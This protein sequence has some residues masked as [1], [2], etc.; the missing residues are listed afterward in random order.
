MKKNIFQ[1]KISLLGSDPLIWRTVHVQPDDTLMELHDIIQIVFDWDELHLWKFDV[2]DAEYSVPDFLSEEEENPFEDASQMT[3]AEVFKKTGVK[4]LYTYDFGDNWEHEVVLEKKVEKN[5]EQIYPICIDGAMAP[6][7]EDIGGI[8]G[9]QQN[10]EILNNP[11]DAQYEEVQEWMGEDF[12]PQA[13][14]KDAINEELKEFA[15]AMQDSKQIYESLPKTDYEWFQETVQGF[16]DAL[17]NLQSKDEIMQIYEMAPLIALARRG[18]VLDEEENQNFYEEFFNKEMLQDIKE[19]IPDFESNPILAFCLIYIL[20]H[21][22]LGMM[23]EEWI[24]NV[25]EHCCN[26]PDEFPPPTFN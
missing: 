3:L 15:E 4:I 9:Y 6:P 11:K 8:P 20:T 5:P 12:D 2:N 19:Q 16:M 17:S 21:V 1:L 7:P 10:L 23:P 13:F 18:I 14:D 22:S 24:P 25:M 26:N